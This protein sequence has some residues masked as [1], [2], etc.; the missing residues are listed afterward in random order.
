M[1]K[2]DNKAIVKVSGY[3]QK[4]FFNKTRGQLLIYRRQLVV[5][6][7]E[8]SESLVPDSA[9]AYDEGNYRIYFDE[10]QSFSYDRRVPDKTRLVIQA[11]GVRHILHLSDTAEFKK[12][13]Y[14][15]DPNRYFLRA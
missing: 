9:V 5:A 6:F 7:G 15:M 10:I 1:S 12:L 8:I 13:I 11:N 4:S 3:W 14:L 2:E